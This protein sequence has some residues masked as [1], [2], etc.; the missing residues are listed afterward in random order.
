MWRDRVVICSGLYSPPTALVTAILDCGAK[1]VICP[2]K[3]PPSHTKKDEDVQRLEKE[4]VGE[5]QV[6]AAAEDTLLPQED[7]EMTKFLTNLYDAIF[8]E[9]LDPTSAVA[10]AI[11][12]CPSVSFA[13]RY[14]KDLD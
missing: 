3:E 10:K 12:F 1:V 5:P 7:D 4:E 9:G 6:L 11:E 2:A 8:L 13:C 14:R